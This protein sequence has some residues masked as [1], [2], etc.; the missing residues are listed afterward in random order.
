M[1][2]LTSSGARPA[3]SRIDS[4]NAVWYG[5][6][7]VAIV[8]P[9][10][11]RGD[12]IPAVGQRDQR[13][14]RLLDQRRD[15]DDVEPRVAGEQ[16]LRLVGDREVGAAG[17]DLLDR[18]RGVRGHVRLDVEPGVLEVAAVERL[19]DPD[20]VGVDVEVEREVERLRLRRLAVARLLLL[21]A[22]RDDHRDRED[23]ERGAARLMRRRAAPTTR[24]CARAPTSAQKRPTAKTERITTA[25]NSRAVSSCAD[26]CSI[27]C[28]RPGV[29]ARPLAEHGPD[30]GDGDGDLG[31][32]EEVGQR[33][34]RLDAAEEL[35]AAGVERAH[36]LDEV[37]IDRAQAVERVDRDR[38][39]A[40]QRDDRQ[41]RADPEAEPDDEDR[42]DDDDRN[43]LRGDEQRDRTPGAAASRGE[44]G[45]RTA[46]RRPRRARTRARSRAA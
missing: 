32:A 35:P 14:Q 25:A 13:G 8:L 30:D 11:S 46:P 19:V 5:I 12:S 10:R 6:P 3:R 7:A 27:R 36:H 24:P 9:A 1:T 31:A 18:R 2:S 28:P 21:A 29:R 37:G 4:R 41:L 17:G 42:R 38:E 22:A 33:G 40:D 16:D 45:R 26:A 43:R 20:V 39:E 15:R 44:A 23:R 34:R